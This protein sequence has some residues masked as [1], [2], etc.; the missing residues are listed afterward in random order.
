MFLTLNI[1]SQHIF[2]FDIFGHTPFEGRFNGL[3]ESE[4]IAGSYIQKLSILS[5]LS[6]IL[7]DITEVKK[8][9]LILFI[10][11]I[12]GIGVLLT[13]DRMPFFIYTFG[14][15]ISIILIKNLRLNLLASF[16]IFIL[17]TSV[18]FKN[19]EILY[20]RYS[21]LKYEISIEKIVNLIQKVKNDNSYYS[22]SLPDNNRKIESKDI[23]ISGDY[24]KLYYS[25]YN[26]WLS[27]PLVGSGV[28]SFGRECL[29]LV[30]NKNINFKNIN[31]STHPHNYYVQI[32]SETGIIGACF[33]FFS[34]IKFTRYSINNLY[35]QIKKGKQPL[36]P[37]ETKIKKAEQ[38]IKQKPKL[39]LLEL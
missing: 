36:K 31:C 8:K 18:F 27:K 4:A 38:E 21:I 35:T 25:A 7:L 29:K 33:I 37:E 11:N 1:F 17:L 22:S 26:V 14:I 2:G 20:K 16:L 28:K 24:N 9:L 34:L 19:Y 39:N 10:I 30:N 6:I 12:L 23:L 32:L 13:F 15:L 3:F 5:I